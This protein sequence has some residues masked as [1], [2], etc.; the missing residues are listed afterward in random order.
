MSIAQNM[1]NI[2]FANAQQAKEAYK[3]NNAKEKINN[4]GNTIKE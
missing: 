1:Y 3:Y 2:I 4:G